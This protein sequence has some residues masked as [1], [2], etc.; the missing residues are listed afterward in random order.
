MTGYGFEMTTTGW[1]NIDR[2]T[3]PKNWEYSPLEFSILNKNTFD[4]AYG[5]VI[6][7]SIKSL[8]RL[9]T[10]NSKT[11]YVGNEAQREMIMPKNEKAIGIVIAYKENKAFLD[12]IEFQT[13]TDSLLKFNLKE[14]S[15]Q[16]IKKS[17]SQFENLPQEN[18]ILEDLKYLDKI[19][20]EELRQDKKLR[21]I[22]V[23][24]QLRRVSTPI[25]TSYM[26]FNQKYAIDLLTETCNN[27]VKN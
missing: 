20:L 21:E 11:F 16:E 22:Y 18:S 4:R 19:Y 7:T 1:I 17:L 3:L 24:D 9:N 5:Y 15:K 27:K 8:Y 23:M 26:E 12:I 13:N 10:N 25:D 2:G 14:Y 6:Y